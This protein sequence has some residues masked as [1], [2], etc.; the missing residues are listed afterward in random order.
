M[1]YIGSNEVVIHNSEGNETI[2][3]VKLIDWY[4]D[5]LVIL[6]RK[7][8]SRSVISCYSIDRMD[9]GDNVKFDFWD[10]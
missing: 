8:G 2:S 10:K 6:K 1:N 9:H 5:S 7:D 4:E 3:D